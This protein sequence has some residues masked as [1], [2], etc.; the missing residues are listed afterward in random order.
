MCVLKTDRKARIVAVQTGPADLDKQKNIR[1]NLDL[2]RRAVTSK[3]DFVVFAELC[4]V[5]Y[6]FTARDTDKRYF[7]Y[8]ETI[9]GMTTEAFTKV[10]REAKC[11]VVLPIYEKANQE[12][13]FYNS[14]ALIGPD[15]GIVEG[16]LP[17]GTRVSC[18]RKNHIGRNLDPNSYTD[19]APYLGLGSGFPIFHTAKAEI[20]IMICRDRWFPES[21]RTL[22]LLGAEVIFVPTTSEGH[23]RESFVH[24]LR[25]W[26]QENQIFAV[27]TNR[28]GVEN[29]GRKATYYGLTCIV[30]PRGELIAQASPE[31][32]ETLVEAEIDLSQIAE[33][34]KQRPYYRDR[35]PE[36]YRI[37]TA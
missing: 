22:A 26:A 1:R 34:R 8:A 17:D 36:L 32:E 16:S 24:T 13:Q 19:E 30:G 28:C 21:W 6:W 3:P 7:K 2:L 9:P 10:A 18:Y 27:G 4:T 37:I 33:I 23:L 31:E 12:G 35:R 20:G 11:Y 14:A 25:T 15:G 29:I 5:P